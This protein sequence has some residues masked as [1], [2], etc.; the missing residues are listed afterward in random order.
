MSIVAHQFAAA[1]R[2]L[3]KSRSVPSAAQ[4]LNQRHRAH[5]AASQNVDGRDLICKCGVFCGDDLE[6]V[7]DPAFLAYD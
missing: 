2:S 6:I 3:G 1:F 5:H 4:S 7:G